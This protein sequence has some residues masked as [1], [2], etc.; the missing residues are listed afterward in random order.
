MNK[1]LSLLLIIA[2]LAL[3]FV[4]IITQRYETIVAGG[5]VIIFDKI[6][7]TFIEKDAK[8][9]WKRREISAGEFKINFSPA[10]NNLNE[11][12]NNEQPPIEK[13]VKKKPDFKI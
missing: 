7:T 2:L 8:G 9:K 6:T 4:I 13:P 12:E 5:K 1:F 11:P 3:A 10:E